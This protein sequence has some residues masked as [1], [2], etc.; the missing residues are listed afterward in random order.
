MAKLRFGIIGAGGITH[1]HAQRITQSGEGEI[2]AIAEPSEPAAARF[3]ERTGTSP[4]RYPDHTAMIGDKGLALDCILIGSPHTLHFQQACDA[5][6]AGLHVLCE[7]PMVCKAEHAEKLIETAQRSGKVF[8][9]SYQRH[10]DPQ[11]LWMK[12]F[13]DSGKL[14]ELHF[15]Q[16]LTCQEWLQLTAGSWRQEPSLGGG[17]QINDTGS[18]LVDMLTW[19]GGPVKSVSAFCENLTAKVDINS[20]VSFRYQ[21]GALGTLSVIGDAAC[22]WEDW[23]ISG[24]K[25]TIFFRNGR[26]MVSEQI[27]QAPREVAAGEL[28]AGSDPDRAFMAAVKEQKPVPVPPEIGLRVIQLTEAAWRSSAEGRPID[29]SELTR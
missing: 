13:I 19:L 28:P 29:V 21:N 27:H 24:S 25:A 18:H 23:T 22:W 20:S 3:A 10:L 16:A 14:G 9:I 1:G 12:Q 6:N 8:M 11:F 17:G 7:K 5:L 2:V 4:K 26:L 15:I